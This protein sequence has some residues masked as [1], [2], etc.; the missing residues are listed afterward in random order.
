MKM[1]IVVLNGS[2]KG[3]ASIT[4]QYMRFIQNKFPQH[5]M[6]AFHVSQL[7]NRIENEILK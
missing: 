3:E 2:P 1:K 5:E 4:P 7:V 6:K